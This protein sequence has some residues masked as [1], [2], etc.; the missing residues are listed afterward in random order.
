[1][2]VAFAAGIVLTQVRQP[3]RASRALVRIMLNQ[4]WAAVGGASARFRLATPMPIPRSTC[5]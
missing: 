3:D 5:N 2:G 1:M 4:E